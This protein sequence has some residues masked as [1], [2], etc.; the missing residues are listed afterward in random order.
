MANE[1]NSIRLWL[2]NNPE[3]LHTTLITNYGTATEK[4]SFFSLSGNNTL[5]RWKAYADKQPAGLKDYFKGIRDELDPALRRA[6]ETGINTRISKL[7][8]NTG[9]S[10]RR[11]LRGMIMLFEMPEGEYD[12]VMYLGDRRFQ[13]TFDPS[14]LSSKQK[15]C[16]GAYYWNQEQ[17]T[18]TWE[19]AF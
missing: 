18:Q 8:R 3:G 7:T 12:F 16:V 19:E 14:L 17:A 15:N 13:G 2:W 5:N 6:R 4:R 9:D 10:G 11:V 1:L